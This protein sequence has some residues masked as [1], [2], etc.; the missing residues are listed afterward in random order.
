MNGHDIQQFRCP[1]I[2]YSTGSVILDWKVAEC[3]AFY[4]VNN[5]SI[6]WNC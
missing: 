3:I 4:S 2:L 5:T 6:A 1:A